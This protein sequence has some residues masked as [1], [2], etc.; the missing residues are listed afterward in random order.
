MILQE[1]I[2]VKSEKMKLYS[3]MMSDRG[4]CCMINNK[5]L[6]EGDTIDDF[7]V[8]KISDDNVKLKLENVEI[9][10]KLSK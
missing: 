4:P 8:V 9:T 5:I 7:D 6:Y 1:Q 10:L 2:R 3:V